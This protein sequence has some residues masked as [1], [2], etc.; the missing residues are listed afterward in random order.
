M[1][2]AAY[3]WGIVA[4]RLLLLL[5]SL[6]LSLLLLPLLLLLLPLLQLLKKERTALVDL[7]LFQ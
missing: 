3:G 4:G 1:R 6:L 5:L 2:S 7:G